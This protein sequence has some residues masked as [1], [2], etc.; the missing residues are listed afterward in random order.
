MTAWDVYESPI[1]PLTVEASDRGLAAIWF[2]RREAGAHDPAAVAEA[3][4][5][6]DEYFARRREEFDLALDLSG[7]PFQLAV[8]DR[9]RQIPYGTT[10]SYGEVARSVGRE[11]ARAVG[12][13]V[14]Q[15][16]VPIVVP[17]HRVIGADLSLT[18]YGGGLEKKKALLALEST[19]LF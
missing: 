5:Q 19:T 11:D 17:C 6:L 15:T 16:P 10:V 3:V 4:A 18:G 8:W 14:G 13:A 7:T 2:G 1:G 12:A 9:L